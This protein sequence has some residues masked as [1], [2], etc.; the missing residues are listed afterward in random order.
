MRATILTLTII[1]AITAA[2]PANAGEAPEQEKADKILKQEKSVLQSRWRDGTNGWTLVVHMK[3]DG[4]NRRG[5]AE[6][7]C[8]RLADVDADRNAK[9]R[10]LVKIVD[11]AAWLA[12]KD[13][14]TIGEIICPKR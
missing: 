2:I 5:F 3:D 13:E 12:K 7:V 11:H 9:G 14:R 6:Y 8:Q 4:T 10:T 1:A